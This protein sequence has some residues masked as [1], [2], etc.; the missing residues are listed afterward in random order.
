MSNNNST[1]RD[2]FKTTSMLAAALALTGHAPAR[3]ELQKARFGRTPEWPLAC[4]ISSYGKY[5]AAAWTHMPS[6]GLH[7]AFLPVPAPDQFEN[8]MKRLSDNKLKRR[9]CAATRTCQ[10]SRAWTNS[11]AGGH[12]R[13]DG[14]QVHVPQRE[15]QR[16]GEVVSTSAC[17]ARVRPPG[18]TASRFRWKRT[19]SFARTATCNSRP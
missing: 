15:M 19:R 10:R 3:A 13:E 5:E 11:R 4:R 2:F 1:R 7:Y 17:A 6:I 9:L 18:N 14:R 16:R 8:V 12:V